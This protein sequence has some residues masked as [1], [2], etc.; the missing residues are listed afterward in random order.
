MRGR[1]QRVE[2][3]AEA[4]EGDVPEVEQARVADDDVEPEPEDDVQEREQPIAE[5]VAAVHPERERGGEADEEGEP[6]RGGH[7]RHEPAQHAGEAGALLESL[8]GL[9][10]P[11]VDADPRTL[12]RASGV[13][14]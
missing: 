12:S 5:E 10:D 14:G 13:A 4:E 9:G 8:V 7:D 6:G 3:R 1:E 11:V 2:V